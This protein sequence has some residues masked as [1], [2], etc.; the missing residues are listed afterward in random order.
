MP[1]PHGR[2]RHGSAGVVDG[3]GLADHGHLDLA[4]VVELL[5]DL[6]GDLVRHEDGV[7]IA[8]LLRLHDHPD[9][10]AGLQSVDAL[11]ARL[12][13][14]QLL[15]GLESLDVRLEALSSRARP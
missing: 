11:D 15:E 9:L 2:K 12:L 5:L 1:R 4:G 3:S 7:V 6:A 8:D 14:G 13:G 10:A